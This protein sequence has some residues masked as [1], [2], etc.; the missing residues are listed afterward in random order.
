[1]PVTG[2]FFHDYRLIDAVLDV[3]PV[4]DTVPDCMP[5]TDTVLDVMFAIVAMPDVMFVTADVMFVTA[6]VMSMID[7]VPDAILTPSSNFL[8]VMNTFQSHPMIF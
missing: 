1:M 4:T 3:M 2:S 7:A 8:D 5:V 6:D